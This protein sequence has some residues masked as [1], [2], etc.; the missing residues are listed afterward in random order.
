M[1]KFMRHIGIDVNIDYSYKPNEHEEDCD[2]NFNMFNKELMIDYSE[3]IPKLKP[4]Y[5]KYTM[6]VLNR[7]FG[8]VTLAK[9]EVFQVKY[10][11]KNNI[12]EIVQRYSKGSFV[13]AFEPLRVFLGFWINNPERRQFRKY[14]FEPE[15]VIDSKHDFNVYLGMKINLN[16]DFSN[17]VYDEKMVIPFQQHV[18]QYFCRNNQICYDYFMKYFARKIQHPGTKNGVGWYGFEEFKTRNW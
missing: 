17:L 1:K 15:N 5:F 14:V 3:L 9:M 4:E 10:D 18:L 12:I 11:N 6:K 8:V 7:Y 16:T 2:F 13:D